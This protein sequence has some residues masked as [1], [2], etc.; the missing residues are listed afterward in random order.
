MDGL[1]NMS[2]T[3]DEKDDLRWLVRSLLK[4]EFSKAEIIESAIRRGYNKRT[5]EKYIK[6][7]S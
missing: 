4:S 2:M 5:V 6:A 7:L 3:N 1:V